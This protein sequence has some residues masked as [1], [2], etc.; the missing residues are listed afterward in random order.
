MPWKGA[1]H[2]LIAGARLVH[3]HGVGIPRRQEVDDIIL[4]LDLIKNCAL[5]FE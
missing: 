5:V 2:R 1:H 4:R 3:T